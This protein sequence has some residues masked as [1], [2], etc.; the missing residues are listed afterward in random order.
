MQINQ[1]R[2]TRGTP[3]VC[4]T[5]ANG[6]KLVDFMLDGSAIMHFNHAE[7]RAQQGKVL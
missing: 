6:C 7:N 5:G 3:R 2:M 4:Y 1:H